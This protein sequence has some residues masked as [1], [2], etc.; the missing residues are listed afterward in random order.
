MLTPPYPFQVHLEGKAYSYSEMSLAKI[1]LGQ[2]HTMAGSVLCYQLPI[3]SD[4]TTMPVAATCAS[5]GATGRFLKIERDTAGLSIGELE[6]IVVD[7]GEEATKTE[8]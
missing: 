7:L 6:I 1:T 4:A 3:I 2:D 5:G 8:A